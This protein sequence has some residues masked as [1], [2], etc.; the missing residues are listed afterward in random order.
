[1]I[2]IYV[3]YMVYR[4]VWYVLLEVQGL[5]RILVWYI[6]HG[7]YYM[8]QSKWYIEYMVYSIDDRWYL[9][10]ELQGSYNQAIPVAVYQL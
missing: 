6:L 7:T 5:E 3:Y 9:L 1:M 4:I 8:V 10:L 2:Y